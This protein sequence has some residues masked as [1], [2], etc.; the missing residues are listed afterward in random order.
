MLGHHLFRACFRGPYLVSVLRL[1]K[2]TGGHVGGSSIT[3]QVTDR[4]GH[5]RASS[6]APLTVH[7]ELHD[8]SERCSCYDPSFEGLRGAFENL[9]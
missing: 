2:G 7:T 5:H 8:N 1:S 3:G 4:A 6:Y 9:G